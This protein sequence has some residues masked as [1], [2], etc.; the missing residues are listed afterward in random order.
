[1]GEEFSIFEQMVIYSSALAAITTGVMA[2]VKSAFNL[3]KNVLP[4]ISI[5]VGGLIGLASAYLF[6]SASLPVL[7][8]AGALSGSAG[9]GLH[10]LFKK[11]EGYTK[12]D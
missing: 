4:L 2:A 3:P 6:P 12:H 1:M 10:E 9:V 8:W 5:I 11:R 7:I